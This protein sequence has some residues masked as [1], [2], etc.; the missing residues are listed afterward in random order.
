MRTANIVAA[1]M[2]IVR[3][4]MEDVRVRLMDVRVEDVIVILMDIIVGVP[5]H[6]S[7]S[8]ERTVHLEVE[9]T[10]GEI[11][12]VSSVLLESSRQ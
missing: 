3:E 10:V 2:D 4:E 5:T 12:P 9:C 6:G 8:L 1:P 11:R 7:A